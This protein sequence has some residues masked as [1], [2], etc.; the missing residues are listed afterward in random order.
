M[1]NR[2]SDRL[3]FSTYS[4]DEG[5]GFVLARPDAEPDLDAMVM[6]PETLVAR[7]VGVAAAYQL[8]HLPMINVYGESRFNEVQRQSLL[9]E[10]DFVAGVLRDPAV[11]EA[12]GRIRQL[13]EHH[14]GLDLVVS[15]L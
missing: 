3:E 7:L 15:G 5:V 11:V 8:H 4:E 13:A 12:V 2:F 14:G 6:I 9:E 10:L 1:V